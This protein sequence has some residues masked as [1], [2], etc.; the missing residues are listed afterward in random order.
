MKLGEEAEKMESKKAAKQRKPRKGKGKNEEEI[1]SGGAAIIL[2]GAGG[3]TITLGGPNESL[4]VLPNLGPEIKQQ[5]EIL[6]KTLEAAE[7]QLES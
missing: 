2:K 7:A 4:Q 5:I 1:V 3:K 6:K